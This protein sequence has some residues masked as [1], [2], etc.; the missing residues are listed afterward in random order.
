MASLEYIKAQITYYE[1]KISETRG[2]IKKMEK[3]Y[4][5][6]R[7]FKAKSESS[8]EA[9]YAANFGK[10]RALE[11]VADY[12]K[13]NSFVEKYYNRCKKGL[14]K[15]GNRIL[16][17]AYEFVLKQVSKELGQN[18]SAI[19]DYEKDIERYN[20]KLD[21]LRAAYTQEEQ[22]LLEAA[23]SEEG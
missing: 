5:S 21:E 20:K 15:T 1:N 16:S 3:E 10:L 11:A 19:N 12:A 23:A 2:K 18:L 13:N 4:E 7:D 17:V 14:S 9:F 6:L 8:Q 22:S